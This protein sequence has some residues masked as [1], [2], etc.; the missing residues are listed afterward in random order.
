[1]SKF[2]SNIKVG[3]IGLGVGEQHIYGYNS[4]PKCD[5]VKIC[6]FNIEKLKEVQERHPQCVPTLDAKEIINDKSIDVVSIASFDNFHF[7]QIMQAIENNKHIFVEKPLCLLRDEYVEIVKE[8]KKKNH[9][10]LSSNL[11][12]RKANR[13]KKLKEKIEKNELGKIYLFEASYDYGRINKI[14]SGWRGEIDNYSVMHGGGIHLIDLILWLSSQRIIEVSAFSTKIATTNSKFRYPDCINAQ[15]KFQDG[16]I[17]NLIANFPAVIKHGHR[18]VIH[19][20]KG[21]FHHGPLGSAY[22]FSR[23]PDSNPIINSDIYPGVK[24]GDMLFSFI[25]SILNS[26]N[27]EVTKDEVFDAMNISL[28]IEESLDTGKIIK[29]NY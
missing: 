6:D 26:S 16:A 5:V 28:A 25:E 11:I 23:D 15:L 4:H 13:F 8:L 29:I 7:S 3:V 27:P 1:M 21:T 9:L 19:G 12:L 18:L 24:K 17:G 20:D 2:K 14:N 10:K 22:F